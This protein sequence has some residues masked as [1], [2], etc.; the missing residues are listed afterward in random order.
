MSWSCIIPLTFE[1]VSKEVREFVSELST[2]HPLTAGSP[3]GST[4]RRGLPL[5][6]PLLAILLVAV[7]LR[8]VFAFGLTRGIRGI[9]PEEEITDGYHLIAEHLH[10]GHGYRQFLSHPPTVQ[11][12]PGYPL[13]LAGLFRVAGIDYA[14]VQVVQALLGALGCWLLF[15]LGRWILDDRIGLVAAA[16]YAVYPNSVQYASRLYA[17]NLYYP[18]FFIFAL[19]L[20]I[21]SS[22]GWARAGLAAGIAWGMGIL[23][24][25]TLLALP[26]ALPLGIAVSPRHRAPARR[27]IRWVLPAAAGAI[28]IVAPWT[29]RNARLTDSFVPVSAWGWAPFYH[30]IQCSKAML[31]W[32]DLRRVDL[33]AFA[34]RHRAVVERLYEGDDTRAYASAREFVRHEEVA[35]SLV[36]EEIRGDPAGF[37]LRGLVGIPFA[38]FQTLGPRM[39]ILSLA[40]HLPLMIL[41][42]W[43][44][45]RLSRR[46]REAFLRAWP[47]LALILFVNLFQAF[48]FPH[49]RYMSP[50][51]ALSFVFSGVAIAGWLPGRTAR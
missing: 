18:L 30:G 21:A 33:E 51:V 6:R 13:F 40:I 22:S 35:R 37:V 50:A 20:C 9:A 32:G 23:T 45:I 34:E 24:R 36:L 42:V 31:H 47:A 14:A 10:E 29:I 8:L 19:L 48:V 41:F 38:W 27:W 28:L 7:L 46:D 2:Q 11:R 16:L 1:S 49:V 15:L 5:S 25:G 12:P 44:V 4:G 3:Q 17:E 39:R 43:G 26:L